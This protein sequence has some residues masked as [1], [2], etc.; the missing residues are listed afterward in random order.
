MG[1]TPIP[2]D[3]LIK[4]LS[5]MYGK[6]GAVQALRGIESLSFVELSEGTETNYISLHSLVREWLETN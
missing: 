3:E 4:S 2:E 5:L 1:P 6:R